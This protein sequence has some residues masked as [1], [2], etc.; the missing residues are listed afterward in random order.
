MFI[1]LEAVDRRPNGPTILPDTVY[2]IICEHISGN[3]PGQV[4]SIWTDKE[5]A[6]RERDELRKRIPVN[7]AWTYEVNDAPLN[8]SGIV[9]LN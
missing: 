1:D 2:L 7:S 3:E 5:A 6:E 8:K 4:L 9:A